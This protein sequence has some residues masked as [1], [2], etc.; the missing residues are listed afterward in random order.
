MVSLDQTSCE[1]LDF[2]RDRERVS[3]LPIRDVSVALV[4]VFWPNAAISCVQACFLLLLHPLYEY[5]RWTLLH[6][7][8]IVTLTQA[9]MSMAAHAAACGGERR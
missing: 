4:W 3:R 1:N 9:P 7:G 2:E 8:C 6:R 5:V